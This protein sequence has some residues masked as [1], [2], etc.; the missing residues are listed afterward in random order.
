[1]LLPWR[2]AAA[3]ALGALWASQRRGLRSLALGTGAGLVFIA[4]ASLM[5]VRVSAGERRETARR[6]AADV[7]W[8]YDATQMHA[9]DYGRL[10]RVDQKVVFDLSRITVNL[11]SSAADS[12]QRIMVGPVSLPAGSYQARIW[13]SEGVAQDGDIIVSSSDRAVLSTRPNLFTCSRS[14]A[15]SR[16]P[17]GEGPSGRKR[18]AD[19]RA[20]GTTPDSFVSTVV[21]RS[22]QRSTRSMRT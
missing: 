20:S 11:G 12:T 2:A 21:R 4:A 17:R 8:A 16:L 3:I 13:F 18:E 10:S 14:T 5:A 7:L 1:M 19:G 22:S 6:G 15:Y 9:L